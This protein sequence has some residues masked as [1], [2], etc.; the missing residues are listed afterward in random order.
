MNHNKVHQLTTNK[1]KVRKM[2]KQAAGILSK[3]IEMV[4]KDTYCPEIIQQVDAIIGLLK[5]AE[6]E[7]LIG[8][9]NHCLEHK[10]K[11][12]KA[13]T[14]EELLKIYKLSS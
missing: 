1:K 2:S 11:E 4:E 10:M 8:H 12:N 13:Q 6:K 3:V 9:L 7:L 14:V 5:S